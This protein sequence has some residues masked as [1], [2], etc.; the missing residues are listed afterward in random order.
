MWE[1]ERGTPLLPAQAVSS[2]T[3]CVGHSDLLELLKM[4]L[5]EAA[6]PPTKEEKIPGAWWPKDSEST[7]NNSMA[8]RVWPGHRSIWPWAFPGGPPSTAS[9]MSPCPRCWGVEHPLPQ[10]APNIFADISP[11]AREIKEKIN[12]WD[13]IKLKGFCTVKETIIKMKREP[14]IWKNIFAN[15]TSKKF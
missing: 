12:K 2:F 10:P 6:T 5:I 13:Y 11:R 14:T 9:P 1:G 4:L 3:S 7:G 15:Y 8:R